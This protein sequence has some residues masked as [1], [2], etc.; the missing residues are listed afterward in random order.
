MPDRPERGVVNN[1][2]NPHALQLSS[3]LV[4][5]CFPCCRQIPMQHWCSCIVS[6]SGTGPNT[7]MLPFL[8][9][10]TISCQTPRKTVSVLVE[11]AGLWTIVILPWRGVGRLTLSHHSCCPIILPCS[12][13]QNINRMVQ[14]EMPY[15]RLPNRYTEWLDCNI[16]KSSADMISG[17]AE[18]KTTFIAMLCK[19]FHL[20]DDCTIFSEQLADGK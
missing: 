14:E 10:L 7:W 20:Y 11:G 1:Y 13:D 6:C 15:R 4:C 16:F 18:V 5:V 17:S 8:W 2:Y 12:S 3:S 9:S 19:H